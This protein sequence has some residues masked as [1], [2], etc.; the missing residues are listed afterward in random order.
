MSKFSDKLDRL[1]SSRVRALEADDSVDTQR[2]FVA[3][4]DVVTK[5][6]PATQP[7]PVSAP[8][9]VQDS[10]AREAVRNQLEIG[11]RLGTRARKPPRLTMT[12]ASEPAPRRAPTP[13]QQPQSDNVVG[14]RLAD[15]RT[16]AEALIAVGGLESA[17]PLLHEMAALSPTHPYPLTQ[18]S[19][20]WRGAGNERLASLYAQRLAAIAPY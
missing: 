9:P 20:Y 17:L 13:T 11:E 12:R 2:V 7:A 16:R 8:P 3:E 19:A 10:P 15:L 5:Q 6:P 14:E 1:H 4:P 18:L